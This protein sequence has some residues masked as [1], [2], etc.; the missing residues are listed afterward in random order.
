M[1]ISDDYDGKKNGIEESENHG[2]CV[3]QRGNK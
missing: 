1:A 3:N 2:L